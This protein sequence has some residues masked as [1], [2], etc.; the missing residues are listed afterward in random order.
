MIFVPLLYIRYAEVF[1]DFLNLTL[2]PMYSSTA[3]NLPNFEK[4]RP[5]IS[6]HVTLSITFRAVSDK[7]CPDKIRL[8]VQKD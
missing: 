4:G 5:C 3:G 7:T 6:R 2:R 1:K 8:H